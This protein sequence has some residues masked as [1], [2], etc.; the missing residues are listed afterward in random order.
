MSTTQRY[1]LVVA[2]C[3]VHAVVLSLSFLHV[4]ML[5]SLFLF[6]A[7]PPW[8]FALWRYRWLKML[9]PMLCGLAI[10][11]PVFHWF[12]GWSAA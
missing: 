8:I 5:L 4:P 1:G 11:Y 3:L 10:M 6:C 2:G 12:T 9:L 7:W